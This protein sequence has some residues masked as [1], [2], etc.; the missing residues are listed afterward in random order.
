MSNT[1]VTGEVRLSYVNVFT[2]KPPLS[3]GEPKYSVMVLLPKSDVATKQAIDTEIQRVLAEAVST[4]FGGQTPTMPAIPIYDG[5]GVRQNGEPFGEECKGHWVF[6]ASS[7][8][9][10]EVVDA[11][12]QPI[13]SSTAVYSGC[14]GRVSIRFFAYNKA[15]KKGV[16]CGLGNIQKL[17]DGEPLGGG[18]TAEQ[19]FGGQSSQKVPNNPPTPPAYPQQGPIPGAYNQPVIDPATGKPYSFLGV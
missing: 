1:I 15:G 3:G 11:N 5:D 19:D 13:I 7:L 16:G 14:Y 10:P 12:V 6:T 18:T 4:T 8:N 2:P 17:R 9:K